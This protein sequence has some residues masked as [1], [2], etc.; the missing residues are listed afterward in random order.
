VQAV[1][2]TDPPIEQWEVPNRILIYR[3]LGS[4]FE[5]LSVRVIETTRRS[6]LPGL[7]LWLLRLIFLRLSIKMSLNGNSPPKDKRMEIARNF[8]DEIFAQKYQP[9]NEGKGGLTL[10]QM[11][12]NANMLKRR[13]KGMRRTLKIIGD[14]QTNAIYSMK[15]E[16]RLIME[17]N[18]EI[19]EK[20][21]E[22]LS[23]RE[24]LKFSALVQI[25]DHHMRMAF[26]GC[27]VDIGICTDST[28]RVLEYFGDPNYRRKVRRGD[29][30]SFTAIDQDDVVVEV[31]FLSVFFFAYFSFKIYF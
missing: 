20:E 27:S 1:A 17:R 2:R 14:P 28:A 4:H 21:L 10:E 26:F 15:T 12:R 7:I 18:I 30:N 13:E 23:T 11:K 6:T 19:L 3:I 8:A 5:T 25:I 24:N 29:S 9:T 16:M 31:S 22:R